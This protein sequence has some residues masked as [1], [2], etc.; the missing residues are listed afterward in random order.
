MGNPVTSI[1]PIPPS[2]SPASSPSILHVYG[3][4]WQQ[5]GWM[6]SWLLQNAELRPSKIRSEAHSLPD[7]PTTAIATATATMRLFTHFKTLSEAVHR[8]PSQNNQSR[9]RKNQDQPLSNI[10]HQ[11]FT[12]LTPSNGNIARRRSTKSATTT[13][14]I[15]EE[16]CPLVQAD[17]VDLTPDACPHTS[18]FTFTMKAPNQHNPYFPLPDP[19]EKR[20]RKRELDS[21]D[22]LVKRV[23]SVKVTVNTKMLIDLF[24]E[25][26]NDL[27]RYQLRNPALESQPLQS[28]LGVATSAEAMQRYNAVMQSRKASLA[29]GTF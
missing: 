26:E 18:A 17:Y 21:I 13:T 27:R 20:K 7:H 19:Q 23:K 16:K 4:L 28:D 5:R 11:E 1:V 10:T 8:R 29:F 12:I 14:T 24:D 2:L 22:G 3:L 15:H 9:S 25:R 6:P